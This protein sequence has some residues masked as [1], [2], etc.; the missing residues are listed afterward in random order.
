MSMMFVFTVNSLLSY[1]FLYCGE[2]RMLEEFATLV[3]RKYRIAP[4]IT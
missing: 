1:C 3:I 4:W 2:E